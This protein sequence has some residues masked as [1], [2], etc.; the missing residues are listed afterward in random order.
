M[1]N[2]SDTVQGGNAIYDT[3]KTLAE[4]IAKRRMAQMQ[5]D[6][7]APVPAE[8]AAPMPEMVAPVAQAPP[9]QAVQPAQTVKTAAVAPATGVTTQE[10]L[11]RIAQSRRSIGI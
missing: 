1:F 3:Q 10:Q 2:R 11:R 4:K 9:T 8:P 6:T 7:T 5:T